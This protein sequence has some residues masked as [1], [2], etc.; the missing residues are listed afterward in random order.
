MDA[1]NRK[2]F[3][4]IMG[5]IHSGCS[6]SLWVR[7]GLHSFSISTAA[8]HQQQTE[9]EMA[10]KIGSCER[11]SLH[12]PLSNPGGFTTIHACKTP[13]ASTKGANGLSGPMHAAPS[14]IKQSVVPGN[15]NCLKIIW[16][17]GSASKRN[18]ELGKT[19][20]Y[21]LPSNGPKKHFR[22]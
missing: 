12:I 7:R 8:G 18:L 14:L 20:L 11:R 19:V 22:G 13:N 9:M 15:F 5:R 4:T 21:R 2:F 3:S 10:N 6:L 1:Q 16:E 17:N